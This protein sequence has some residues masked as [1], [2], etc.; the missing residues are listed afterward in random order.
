MYQ[1]TP[2]QLCDSYYFHYQ[3][4]A[5]ISRNL[6]INSNSHVIPDIIFFEIEEVE[7]KLQFYIYNC[8]SLFTKFCYFFT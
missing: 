8:W 4:W 3:I 1:E 5:A 7:R 6:K 2:A